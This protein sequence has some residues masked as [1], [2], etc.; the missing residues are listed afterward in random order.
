MARDMY[1]ST[2]FKTRY[3]YAQKMGK[4]IYI[5]SAKYGLI[6]PNNIIEPYDITLKDFSSAERKKWAARVVAKLEGIEHIGKG[7]G[8]NDISRKGI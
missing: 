5:I 8:S 4:K 1:I 3:K 7:G 6:A 2:L